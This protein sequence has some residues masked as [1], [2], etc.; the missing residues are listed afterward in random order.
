M[1]LGLRGNGRLLALPRARLAASADR[2]DSAALQLVSTRVTLQHELLADHDGVAATIA[3]TD[4][5]PPPPINSAAIRLD[6]A[7]IDAARHGLD[8]CAANVLARIAVRDSGHGVRT[9]ARDLAERTRAGR[10]EVGRAIAKLVAAKL[11]RVTDRSKRAGALFHY[12]PG[13]HPSGTDPS[14]SAAGSGPSGTDPSHSAAGSGPSGTDPSHS[15]AGSGPSG[16]DPSHSAAGSGPSGTDPSHSYPKRSIYLSIYR[17]PHGIHVALMRLNPAMLLQTA[18]RADLVRLPP[19]LL[20]EVADRFVAN[21]AHR[22][23][24]RK[25]VWRGAGPACT[26]FQHWWPKCQMPMPDRDDFL[27]RVDAALHRGQRSATVSAADSDHPA[28]VAERLRE[29]RA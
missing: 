21:L 27:R 20:G 18:H 2:R 9:S 10:N 12:R 13:G 15:A 7:E 22:I 19:A 6:C 24:R 16:T 3:P 14:H 4:D 1:V 29:K 8:Q 11:V 23:T 25:F 17:L 28:L 26:Y 5:E